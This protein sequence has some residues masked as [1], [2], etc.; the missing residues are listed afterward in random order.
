MDVSVIVC[1]Y[2][3]AASLGPMLTSLGASVVDPEISWELLVV[4]NNSSDSTRQV[5]ENATRAFPCPVRYLFEGRQ[6][7]SRALNLA[8]AQARGELL[9]FTDDDVNVHPG[10]VQAMVDGFAAHDCV[11]IGGKV[12]A[13]WHQAKPAWYSNTGRYR[14]YG[15]IVEY[16]FG[17]EARDV[18]SPPIGA[19]MAFRREA[20]H[21]YGLFRVDL[22]VCGRGKERFTGGDT[23]FAR[24]VL[25]GGDRILYFPAAVIH[26]PVEAE[27][28]TKRYFKQ[29]Y[30]GHGRTTVRVRPEGERRGITYF[31]VPR[32]L[33]R[34]LAEDGLRWLTA[35][36]ARRRFYY[37]L[38]CYIHW[39]EIREY[40]RTRREVR[41]AQEGQSRHAASA[42]SSPSGTPPWSQARRGSH[43]VTV[44]TRDR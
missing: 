27:R 18:P 39:G 13:G 20:F 8:I 31:G 9:L 17:D 2:N 10:W 15:A 11:G 41:G 34:S 12:E 29:Y 5:V 44:D 24:R 25:G 38:Q 32:Y 3:R 37:Q 22:S 23:E 40:Y 1:T 30:Y 6:G 21:R 19:N 16:D 42:T 26:H 36:G 43:G 28:A 35:F 7:K 4:D 14:L 33:F